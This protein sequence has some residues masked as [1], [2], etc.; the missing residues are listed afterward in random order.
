MPW[1]TPTQVPDEPLVRRI[2]TIL[3]RRAV[4]AVVVFI[5]ILTSAVAFSRFLPDLYEANAIV[6]VERQLPES[7]VRPV[8][9]GELESRLHVIK[10]EILSRA[11][12]TALI[13]RFDLYPAL[14]A[15]GEMETAIEQVRRDIQIELTGPEQVSGR[16]KTVAFNLAFT[17][18]A[19]D[20]VAEVTNA[21][22]QF[23]VA[24][25]SEMR[26][27]EATRTA[28]FLAAQVE[29]AKAQ[30]DRNQKQVRTYTDQ[31]VGELPQQVS[32]NLATLDRLNTQLR[33][34]GER[35]MRALDQRERM[36][37][38]PA[39]LPALA[40]PVT[41]S[42]GDARLDK[43][44]RDLAA[45]EG[46]PDKHPDVRR[47]KDE[48]AAL[49][50]EAGPA[51]RETTVAESARAPR[52]DPIAASRARSLE[53]LATEYDSL[54]AEEA[55]IRQTIATVERRLEG[56]PYR[57]NE[58]SELSRDHQATREQYDTLVK[59]YEEA[60]LAQSMETEQQGERFRI[61]EAAVPPMGPSAPNRVR[62]LIM[63]LFL[64]ALAAGF[65]VLVVEQFDT[66]FHSIDD[67][68]RFTRVPVLV[69]IPRTAPWPANGRLRAVV[70]T[71]SVLAGFVAVGTLSAYVARDNEPLVRLL[72]RGG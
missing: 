27:A 19:R 45:L 20:T 16:S 44:K 29:E 5:A 71:A 51:P 41:A 23:Y 32:V 57:Q 39:A 9:S 31:H 67:L 56:V 62:V 59:R 14:R 7:F 37:D 30:L 13:N 24:E 69:A 58:F 28:E 2:L 25:N 38:A 10:Q 1:D 21:I 54:R 53:G 64:A 61:L 17:G 68:R 65:A 52:P 26:A 55:T 4:V 40:V 35:Q 15:R 22:A 33:L 47:L 11:R 48:I 42:P 66:S 60:Q 63:G 8:V 12:L 43:L 18:I 50:N 46:F 3:R 36:L 6:L 49:E 34:N 72:V 70:V